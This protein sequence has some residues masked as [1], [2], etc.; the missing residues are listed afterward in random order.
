MYGPEHWRHDREHAPDIIEEITDIIE[1]I[2]YEENLS[3]QIDNLYLSYSKWFPLR[4]SSMKRIIQLLSWFYRMFLV[5]YP[6]MTYMVLSCSCKN[7]KYFSSMIQF[8]M[9]WSIHLR[10]VYIVMDWT[11]PRD[12]PKSEACLSLLFSY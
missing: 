9:R 8:K 2:L 7:I 3:K 10:R 11:T 12:E 5:L 4:Y 6:Y 1:E